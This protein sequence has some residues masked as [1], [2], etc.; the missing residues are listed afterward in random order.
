LVIATTSI[1]GDVVSNVAGAQAAVEVLIPAGIDPHDFAPSAQQ[2]ASISA[3]DL[4]V[5]NGLGL[6]EGLID[7]LDQARSEGLTVLE[8]GPQ[9]DPLPR[10]SGGFDPHYWQDPRRMVTAVA[11][12]AS[13]LINDAGLGPEETSERAAAYALEI[14]GA[15]LEADTLLSTV[16]P[17]RRLLIT[18]HDAFEYFADAYGFEVI[19][20]II[21]GGSTRAEPSSAD[22]AHLVDLISGTGISAIFIENTA[23]PAWAEAVATDTARELAI[24]ELISDALGEPG[25]ESDSYVDLVRYN[26]RAVAG[27]LG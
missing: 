21:P 18:N 23:N 12:V 11:L 9:L 8:L 15:H 26:A 16:P 27:A 25:S 5:A 1:L 2:V 19:G 6:E 17:E 24:V 3:A 13:A 7:V 10:D 4:I 22:L 14:E 20:T